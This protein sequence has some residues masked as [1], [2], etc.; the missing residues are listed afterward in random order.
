MRKVIEVLEQIKNEPTEYHKEQILRKYCEEIIET[1][2][3]SF[4]CTMEPD[5][6]FTGEEVMYTSHPVL[7]RGSVLE[8]KKKL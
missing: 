3:G 5:E 2:A 8:V 4:E 7:M 6:G 1:C